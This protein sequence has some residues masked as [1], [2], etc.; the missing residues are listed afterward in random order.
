MGFESG[1]SA[2]GPSRAETGNPRISGESR[3]WKWRC[4]VSLK[5]PRSVS[6][7]R[8][9]NS[10]FSDPELHGVMIAS[11]DGLPISHNFPESEAEWV[12]TMA[13]TAIGL[14]KRIT[15][16]TNLVLMRIEARSSSRI[17]AKVLG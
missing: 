1:C 7:N 15:E 6:W 8:R 17:V 14:G 16:R 5:E 3:A 12:A 9:L 13:A 4:A 10:E 11:S 2:T